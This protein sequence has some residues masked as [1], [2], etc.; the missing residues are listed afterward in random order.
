M[1]RRLVV[2][3]LRR[4]VVDIILYDLKRGGPI[5]GQLRGCAF[6]SENVSESHANGRR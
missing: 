3:M 4:V 5:A 2:R 6:Y 1:I